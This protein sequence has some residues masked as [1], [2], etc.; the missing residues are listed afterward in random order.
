MLTAFV[1]Y[2]TL[3]ALL[4]NMD[5]SLFPYLHAVMLALTFLSI[6]CSSGASSRSLLMV[7]LIVALMPVLVMVSTKHP[8]PLGDDARFIG[9]AA[10]IENDGRWVPFKYPENSYYQFF[11][12]IPALEYILASVT[13]VS[14]KSITGIMSCY[15]TLKLTLYLT[16]FLLLFLVVRKL[17][18]NSSGSLA[19]LL[20]LS[21]TPPLAKMDRTLGYLMISAIEDEKH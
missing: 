21:M 14:I 1:L 5:V 3:T 17:V 4:V 18:G 13:G 20:L 8:L 10:A 11:H 19:S 6:S 16:Y 2:V 15:L 7:T 9:F 12:L